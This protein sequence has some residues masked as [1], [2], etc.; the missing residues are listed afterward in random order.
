MCYKKRATLT[1]FYVASTLLLGSII[2][3]QA[4]AM[5]RFVDASTGVDILGCSTLALPCQ[6]IA[7][8][9]SQSM[10]NDIIHLVSA[11]SQPQ[12]YFESN[13]QIPINLTIVSDTNGRSTIDA[14]SNGRVFQ[15]T[16]G[17]VTMDKLVIQNGEAGTDVGGGIHLFTGNLEINNSLIRNNSALSGGGIA[18]GESAGTIVI[19]KSALL[20]NTASANGGGIRCDECAGITVDRSKVDQN[21]A[22]G[23]GG[24]I[25]AQETQTKIFRS[26]L[27]NN[28]ADTG[29][30][31]RMLVG[32]MKIVRS[33]LS[34][35]EADSSDGGAIRAAGNLN[36]QKTTMHNNRAESAGGAI[37]ANNGNSIV[38]NSTFSKNTAN[39]GGAFNFSGGLGDVQVGAST[40]F[41]NESDF[42]GAAEHIF[43]SWNTF[44]MSNT[45]IHGNGAGPISVSNYCG[46]A[47]TGGQHNLIDDSSCNPAGV[48]GFNLGVV[49][50]FVDILAFNGGITRNHRL[51]PGSNAIDAG[52]TPNCVNP[53]TGFPLIYDQRRRPRPVDG[54]SSGIAVCDIGSY[55]FQ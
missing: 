40:F 55:E 51:E 39:V 45:I 46:N 35:N 26:Y 38:S 52:S 22:G 3:A 30:A 23:S 15:I 49:N 33:E 1:R 24:G 8:T 41:K 47:L 25:Y 42:P 31:V 20:R 29:G 5:D 54:N 10:S 53:A 34:N 43:G 36:V 14:Q 27:R 9:I 37:S 18:A 21:I 19:K 7:F 44:E 6:S 11:T 50:G 48:V 2:S 12:T 17:D 16:G 13:I 4:V 28:N 32:N